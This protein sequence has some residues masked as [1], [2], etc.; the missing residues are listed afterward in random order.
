MIGMA[1]TFLNN[2]F[3]DIP[4]ELRIESHL[5]T[6]IGTQIQKIRISKGLTQQEFA[7]E[8]EITQGLLS[9]YENGTEN[10]T[11]KSVAKIMGKLNVDV[12][13]R[14]ISMDE[15][16]NP[17]GMETKTRKT[18]PSAVSYNK[19]IIPGWLA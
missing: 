14:F 1:K 15:K 19:N 6:E 5:L 13:F 16:A 18:W 9:R 10:F 17:L 4:L 3:R 2:L 11:I 7:E 8:L 12:E